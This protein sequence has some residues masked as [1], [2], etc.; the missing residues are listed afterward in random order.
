L[1]QDLLQ[2]Q[3]FLQ[4]ISPDQSFSVI[5]ALMMLTF[6]IAATGL[7]AWVVSK[8]T[9]GPIPGTSLG[10]LAGL[11]VMVL[12]S[13]LFI[14][15]RPGLSPSSGGAGT[16]TIPVC[17]GNGGGIPAGCTSPGVVILSCAEYRAIGGGAA[18]TYT[19]LNRKFCKFPDREHNNV[20]HNFSV[21]G[22]ECGWT[23]F[24]VT[25]MQ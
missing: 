8:G 6:G 11:I 24:T 23:G 12:G 25:C 19:E 21:E 17:A 1:F 3:K 16:Q 22:G 13:V 18:Q 4:T 20:R 2:Q 5:L 10:V 7:V 15:L 14:S 9:T